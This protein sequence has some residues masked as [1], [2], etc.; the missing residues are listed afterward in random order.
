[1]NKRINVFIFLTLFLTQGFLLA[2]EPGSGVSDVDGNFYRTV[3]VGKIEWMRSNLATTH[4]SN[5]DPI[6]LEVDS[7]DWVY[8]KEPIYTTLY[9]QAESARSY[10]N[11]YN[12]YAVNDNRN[13]CPTGWH[14]ATDFEWDALEYL[15]NSGRNTG[16]KLKSNDWKDDTQG[17]VRDSQFDALPGGYIMMG[18]H[19][20]DGIVGFWWTGSPF[21]VGVSYARYI[22]YDDNELFRATYDNNSGLSVRCVRDWE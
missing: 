10:G 15:L 21:I 22:Q 20:L 4:Y 8:S 19:G 18:M 16:G 5:G 1:M 2:Q 13:I 11:L 6:R 7:V 3:L 17:V 9:N 12:W 14:V